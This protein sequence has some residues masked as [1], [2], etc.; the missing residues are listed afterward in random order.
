MA[1]QKVLFQKIGRLWY[2]FRE[3]ESE[4]IYAPLPSGVDP[5]RSELELFEVIGEQLGQGR[6]FH[7]GKVNESAA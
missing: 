5:R 7:G 6:C 2:V 1:S 3:N 4:V